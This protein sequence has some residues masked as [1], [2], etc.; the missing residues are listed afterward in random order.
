MARKAA[1][2]PAETRIEQKPASP[3]PAQRAPAR[4]AQPK[5]ANSVDPR[6]DE[7]RQRV[8]EAAY[9]LAERRGFTPG[10]EEQDWLQAEAEV[11]KR[12][13]EGTGREAR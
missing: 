3:A 9:Y 7:F 10:Y 12:E 11:M 6:S 2:K 8:S 4:A 13:G 1:T 5:V